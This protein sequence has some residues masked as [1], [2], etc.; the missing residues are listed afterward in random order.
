MKKKRRQRPQQK[1]TDHVETVLQRERGLFAC[2]LLNV[3]ATCKCIS[4]MVSGRGPKHIY[5]GGPKKKMCEMKNEENKI[6]ADRNEILKTCTRFYTELYSST[7]QDQ[8][9]SLKITNSDSSEVPTIMTS[10]VK[11]TLKEMENNKAPGI[12]NL[13]SDIMKLG[14]EESVKQLTNIFNQIIR[15]KKRP[16]LNGK[17]PR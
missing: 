6:Q 16:Q 10:E 5:K 11:K 15:L 7:P 2:W 17:K 13:T 1:Q 14:G 9:P 8:H 3:P 12:D 4:G